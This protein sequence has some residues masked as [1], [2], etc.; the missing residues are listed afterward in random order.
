MVRL[1]VSRAKLW[2][3]DLWEER[4][5]ALLEEPYGGEGG[6]LHNAP[7]LDVNWNEDWEEELRREA[8]PIDSTTYP[9]FMYGMRQLAK[10]LKK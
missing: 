3:N 8:Q 10:G 2:A 5:G 4:E 6:V 7:P 1:A 9:Y